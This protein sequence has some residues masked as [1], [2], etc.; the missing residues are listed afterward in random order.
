MGATDAVAVGGENPQSWCFVLTETLKVL[1]G[2]LVLCML[3]TYWSS[4]IP[5]NNTYNI[6]MTSLLA[7][8][9]QDLL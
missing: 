1:I 3:T 9:L 5:F 2:K 4:Q 7:L 8:N 6:F